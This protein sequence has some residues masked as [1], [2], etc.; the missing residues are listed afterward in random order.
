VVSLWQCTS[1]LCKM[2]KTVFKAVVWKLL[3]RRG[4]ATNLAAEVTRYDATELLFMHAYEK[5]CLWNK[6]ANS[7]R[8]N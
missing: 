1:T 2:C 8:A 5:L 3:N 6:T 7:S 4:R